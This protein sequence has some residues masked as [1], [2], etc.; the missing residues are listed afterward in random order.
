M[1]QTNN[2]NTSLHLVFANIVGNHF[3]KNVN[4]KRV[5]TGTHN[6]AQHV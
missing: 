2:T 6:T 4:W 3:Q 5:K 1:G